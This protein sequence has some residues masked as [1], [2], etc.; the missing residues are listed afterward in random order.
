VPHTIVMNTSISAAGTDGVCYEFFP[1]LG[2]AKVFGAHTLCA[3]MYPFSLL[4]PSLS[5]LSAPFPL[6]PP[7]PPSLSQSDRRR[8]QHADGCPRRAGF[9]DAAEGVARFCVAHREA[10]CT[11]ARAHVRAHGYPQS[12]ASAQK[13]VHSVL[14][15]RG[16]AHDITIRVLWCA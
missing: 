10:S 14:L 12:H 9:G 2:S 15:S 6:Y 8:C 16:A 11:S 4:C 3:R 13:R 5:F 1:T 7:A